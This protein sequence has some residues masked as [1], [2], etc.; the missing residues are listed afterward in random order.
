[1][2]TRSQVIKLH[3]LVF[4]GDTLY[5]ESEIPETRTSKFRSDAGIFKFETRGYN[6]ENDLIM[7]Y[8]RA[9]LIKRRGYDEGKLPVYGA[10]E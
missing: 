6:Q 3:K 9:V 1:M 2:C 8:R 4:I 10:T 5:A 7:S